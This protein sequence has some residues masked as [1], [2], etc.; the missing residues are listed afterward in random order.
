[1]WLAVPTCGM[2]TWSNNQDVLVSRGSMVEDQSKV[3][4]CSK[5]HDIWD[6]C[7]VHCNRNNCSNVTSDLRCQIRNIIMQFELPSIPL[8]SLLTSFVILL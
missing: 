4:V 2:V 7:I 3:S 1:M 6:N 5:K 8:W